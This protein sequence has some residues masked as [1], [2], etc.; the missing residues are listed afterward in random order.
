M[1]ANYFYRTS[2]FVP[3]TFDRVQVKIIY[4]NKEQELLQIGLLKK[5]THPLDW[6]FSLQP[7][8]NQALDKLDWFKLSEQGVS[9]WQKEKKFERIAD[10]VNNLPPGKIITFFYNFSP[11]ALAGDL[12]QEIIIKE[13]N[14]ELSLSEADYVIANYVSPK[15][16]SL[17]GDKEKTIE[18]WAGQEHLNGNAYEFMISAPTLNDYR[19]QIKVKEVSVVLERPKTTW[20]DFWFDLKSYI[21]RKISNVKNKF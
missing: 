11:E 2:L 3:R 20:P 9:L 4:Q 10:F 16:I 13:W 12:N 8:E 5:R 21:S 17:K 18:F 15:I 1:L 19:R 6:R 7:L 14:K